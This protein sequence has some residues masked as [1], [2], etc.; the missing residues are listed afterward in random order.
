M[1]KV[2]VRHSFSK[3][4]ESILH[5]SEDNIFHKK[6]LMFI[7]LIDLYF[8]NFT[9]CLIVLNIDIKFNHIVI[10]Y[11]FTPGNF[12]YINVTVFRC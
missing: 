5:S 6:S 9:I 1:S 10:S 4:D 11:K 2:D 12:R 7:L 8:S 3:S